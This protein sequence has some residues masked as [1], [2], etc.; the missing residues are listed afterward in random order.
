MKAAACLFTLL[1]I[2][3]QPSG[4]DQSQ[5]APTAPKTGSLPKVRSYPPTGKY[6]GSSMGGS[7]RLRHENGKALPHISSRFRDGNLE[8]PSPVFRSAYPIPRLTVRKVHTS[9]NLF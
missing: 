9:E 7:I 6:S 3:Q 8:Y 5:A 2:L 4:C 1:L